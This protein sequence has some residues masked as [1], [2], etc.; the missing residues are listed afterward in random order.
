MSAPLAAVA[1]AGTWQVREAALNLC[2]M[3]LDAIQ[4]RYDSS[5]PDIV[6]SSYFDRPYQ[7][8]NSDDQVEWFR[9]RISDPKIAQLPAIGSIDFICDNVPI[10]NNTDD[11]R[12][13]IKGLLKDSSSS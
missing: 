13:I 2:Y 10:L 4:K 12:T 1:N 6:I 3:A 5:A 11:C 9:S 8:C 7:V